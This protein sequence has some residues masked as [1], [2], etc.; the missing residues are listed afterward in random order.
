MYLAYTIIL[1]MLILILAITLREE[2]RIRKGVTQGIANRYWVLREKRRFVRFRENLKIR[3]NRIGS[4]LSPDNTKMQNMSKTGLCIS[5]YEKLKQKDKLEI[6][7]EV[8]GFS[9]SVKLIGSVIWVKQL[10][11]TDDHGRR[12][13]HTGIRFGKIGPEAEAILITYLNTLKRH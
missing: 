1:L 4:E 13:F 6:E 2:V 10:Q 11:S 12:L 9:K 8:P 7:V 3:Y 5:A